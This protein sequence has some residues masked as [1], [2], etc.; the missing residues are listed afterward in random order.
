VILP[1]TKETL[2]LCGWHFIKRPTLEDVENRF[3]TVSGKIVLKKIENSQ[4]GTLKDEKKNVTCTFTLNQE[5][6]E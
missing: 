3:Q 2:I 1:R 5:D 4:N 6:I